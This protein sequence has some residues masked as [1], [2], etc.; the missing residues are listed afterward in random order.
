MLKTISALTL[1]AA[2]VTAPAF[3]QNAT[4]PA[5]VVNAPVAPVTTLSSSGLA[6]ASIIGG[7]AVIGVGAIAIL[8]SDNDDSSGTSTVTSTSGT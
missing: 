1:A 2:S 4:A 6:G 8:A 5:N 3:A 7:I